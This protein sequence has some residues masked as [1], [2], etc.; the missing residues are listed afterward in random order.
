MTEDQR[1]EDKT[2]E[3][4]S[5]TKNLKGETIQFRSARAYRFSLR[6][7]TLSLFA[8]LLA[9]LSLFQVAHAP[10]FVLFFSIVM[11]VLYFIQASIPRTVDGESWL[12]RWTPKKWLFAVG[13][14]VGFSAYAIIVA[15]LM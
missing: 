14:P 11:L 10:Q 4:K 1:P 9:F 15:L 8:L 7:A 13:V 2:P 6:V 12:D 3:E 5:S